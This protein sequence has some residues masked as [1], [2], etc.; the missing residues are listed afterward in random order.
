MAWLYD[1]FRETKGFFLR[2]HYQ[3]A[4]SCVDFL[5]CVAFGHWKG[6]HN[7]DVVWNFNSELIMILFLWFRVALTCKILKY[8]VGFG[9]VTLENFNIFYRSKIPNMLVQSQSKS[10]WINLV[11]DDFSYQIIPFSF[12][13]VVFSGWS[14]HLDFPRRWHAW[15]T[16][17]LCNFFLLSLSLFHDLACNPSNYTANSKSWQRDIF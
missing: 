3:Q 15:K 8:K 4:L 16:P 5:L 12:E 7:R 6:A 2:T 17:C 10:S 11:I 14:C 13:N 1:Y 9:E